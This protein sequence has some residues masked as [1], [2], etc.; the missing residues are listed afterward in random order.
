ML[1][2][3]DGSGAS[4]YCS[5]PALFKYVVHVTRRDSEIARYH[6]DKLITVVHLSSRYSLINKRKNVI[7]ELDIRSSINGYMASLFRGVH[8]ERL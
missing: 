5:R 6:Y 7:L 1:P 3:C 8:S 4:G 2:C